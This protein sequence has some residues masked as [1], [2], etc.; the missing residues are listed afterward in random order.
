MATQNGSHGVDPDFDEFSKLPGD[1]IEAKI[2]SAVKKSKVVVFGR[3]TCPFCIE[4][5]RTLVE[6][7][8]PFTYYRIDL[9]SGSDGTISQATTHEALKNLTSQRTLPYVY[10]NG[11][12]L[13]GCDATK[14]LISTGE[15]DKMLG[16]SPATGTGTGDVDVEVGSTAAKTPMKIVG[17]DEDSTKITGAL[18]EFPN[19]VDG[20]V[21]RLVGFQVCIISTLLAILAY[22]K[23]QSWHWVAVG[24]LTDFCLRFYAGAGISPLGSIAMF[25]AAAWDLVG[26]RWFNR[27]T[28]PVWGAGPPKQFAVSVGIFF[29]A[30]IVIFQFTHVWPAATVFA[31]GLAAASFLEWALNFCAGCWVFGYA[32]RFGII[33]D[34]VYIVHINTLPETKLT[35]EDW[36]KTVNPPTPQKFRENFRDYPKNT[37]IDLHYKTLKTTDWERE[38]FDYIK[39]SKIAFFS[40]VIGVAAVPA[41]FKFMSM[42]PR[43]QT[44]DLIW[45][46]LTLLSL[47]YTVIF[48]VPYIIKWIKYPQKI[49]SEWQ[50]PMMNNAFTVP[51]MTL[52]V[53][54]FLATGNYSTPLARVLFWIGS[55]T[56]FFLSI[57]I[58]GNILSTIRHPGHLNGAWQMAPVGLY[59]AAVVGPIVDPRYTQVCFLFFGFASIMY[60]TL[61]IMTFQNVAI[62]YLA[63]PRQRMFSAIWFAAPSVASIAWTVLTASAAG[64]MYVMDPI[65]QTL[66]YVGIS[67]GLL[68]IWM[69]WRRFLW[70]DKF[71][72]QM[73][74]FGFPTA[75]LA[76]A[77]VLY[78]GTVQTALTK[79]LAVVCIC[80]ACVISFVLTMRTLAGIARLKVFIPEHKWGP[81]S[82]LPLFQE[83]ARTLLARIGTTTEALA[84][85]P[86][87]TRLLSSLKNSWTNFTTINTFYSTIKRDICLPQIGDFFPGHQAQALANN[88]TM[89]QEQMKIDALLSSPAA[90]TVALKTAMTD[91][92]QLCRDTYDHVEDHIRPVVRRYI[93]GPVQKKIMV[94][95]WDDA[96]KEGWWATIPIVVQNLPMQAQRLTYIRA[97]LWAMPERCQQ[98][99]TMVALG[100]DS[101]TWYRLKHQL[102]EIIPR[103]EAGWKKF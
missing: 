63:D 90:D 50:H 12:L 21:I 62:N 86:S 40:S 32:I 72:M 81:M 24:L 66:F 28:G 29:S 92:I 97:F 59:I 87:N 101:V 38:D 43:F 30:M 56:A 83:A 8:V 3:S 35:W 85:D 58:I 75:A 95:C 69:S 74:A 51:S 70:A 102:P 47:V 100:V 78:D 26:P 54:A 13:G 45:Q 16:A 6:Q 31:A 39:H 23:D 94:D 33:P 61:F 57:I 4:I 25:T 10:V 98:I 93:P 99:G 7:A 52:I 42:A 1:T 9:F 37:K 34:S 20:R 19:T 68:N 71:F 88:E 96:P 27:Q 65:A 76:W 48:T 55:S 67:M 80:V 73:H 53:Y 103:G 17:V 36:T 91:F 15:F 14:E 11:N 82:H 64:G 49:K 60:I 79:V 5:T 18:L 84:E 44:S 41:L 89:I 77:A 46:I 2:E 22:K